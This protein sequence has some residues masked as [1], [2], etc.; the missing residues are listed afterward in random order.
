MSIFMGQKGEIVITNGNGNVIVL[1]RDEAA[2]L[3]NEL[4]K[5]YGQEG[6][7]CNDK[8]AVS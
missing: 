4:C 3:Y 6:I 7:I 8:N 1:S 5:K 2:E